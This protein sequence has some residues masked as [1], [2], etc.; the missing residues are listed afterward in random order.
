MRV[1]TRHETF[2][3]PPR[4][5]RVL[6]ILS[7]N[8]NEK[9]LANPSHNTWHAF[10]QPRYVN[11]IRNEARKMNIPFSFFFFSFLCIPR[12]WSNITDTYFHFKLPRKNILSLTSKH[13]RIFVGIIFKTCFQYIPMIWASSACFYDFWNFAISFLCKKTFRVCG[14]GQRNLTR[15]FESFGTKKFKIVRKF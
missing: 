6:K 9:L 12:S 4:E 7:P 3:A 14:A 8:S 11:A 13:E 10:L 2:P 5:L 1:M 15:S